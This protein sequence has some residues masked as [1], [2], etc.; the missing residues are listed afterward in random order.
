MTVKTYQVQN[1]LRTYGRQLNRRDALLR[2]AKLGLGVGNKEAAGNVSAEAKRQEVISRITK[3]LVSRIAQQQGGSGRSR[4]GEDAEALKRLSEEYGKPLS[5]GL[6][7]G[8]ESFFVVD[9][10]AGCLIPLPKAESVALRR[11]LFELTRGLVDQN[12]VKAEEK[13]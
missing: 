10:Q 9:E 6:E 1:V 11:R 8:V 13:V 2:M 5:L 7:G 4:R 12:M 3:E